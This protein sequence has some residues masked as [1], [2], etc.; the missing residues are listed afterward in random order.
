M[1]RGA[2]EVLLLVVAMMVVVVAG[3]ADSGGA[4]EDASP[5]SVVLLP[6]EPSEA[7]DNRELGML[8]PADGGVSGDALPEEGKESQGG[9]TRRGVLMQAGEVKIQLRPLSDFGGTTE[10]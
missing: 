10:V 9:S 3:S 5:V 1:W 6:V 4:S 2:A 8:R 7:Q